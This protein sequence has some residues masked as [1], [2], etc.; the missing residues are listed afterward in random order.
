MVDKQKDYIAW[1]PAIKK[2]LEHPWRDAW[3]ELPQVKIQKWIE[4]IP[5]YIKPIIIVERGNDFKEGNQ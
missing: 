3:K 5:K 1:S 4:R 2:D